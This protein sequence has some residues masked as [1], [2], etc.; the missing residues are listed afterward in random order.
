MMKLHRQSSASH[1]TGQF[2]RERSEDDPPGGNTSMFKLSSYSPM[3]GFRAARP[4]RGN[5][6]LNDELRMKA[7]ELE[8]HYAAY[9]LKV[10]HGARTVDKRVVEVHKESSS[11][12]NGESYDG[13][14]DHNDFIRGMLYGRY[15]EKRDVKLREGRRSKDRAQ[16][17]AK[18]KAMRVSLEQTHAELKTKI[19]Q[20]E[21]VNIALNQRKGGDLQTYKHNEFG[22]EFSR[23]SRTKN[24]LSSRSVSSATSLGLAASARPNPRSGIPRAQSKNSSSSRRSIDMN[25]SLNREEKP[26]RLT[27]KS[28]DTETQPFLKKG[29]SIGPSLS[30]IKAP[31]A[32]INVSEVNCQESLVDSPALIDAS[33]YSPASSQASLR[34]LQMNEMLETEI[35][36]IHKLT[37][38]SP[39]KGFRR[40]LNFGRKSNGRSSPS[41]ECLSSRDDGKYEY[42]HDVASQSLEGL[43]KSNLSYSASSGISDDQ[44]M[45]SKRELIPGSPLKGALSFFSLPS[46]KNRGSDLKDRM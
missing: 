15:M 44:E 5:Q 24:I 38:S 43:R 25:V 33:H 16:R 32:N 1:Q 10:D 31:I 36:Q 34:S 41:T 3:T 12:R 4:R 27:K 42:N 9:R 2:Q 21:R 14:D 22:D 35:K 13:D 39:S 18:M 45:K 46:F 23:G 6:E 29:R 11:L 7:K 20:S 28:I 17:E 19:D 30:K 26:P 40:F 37:S 8:E